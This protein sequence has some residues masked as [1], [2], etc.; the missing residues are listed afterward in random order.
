MNQ[1]K[2]RNI[3]LFHEIRHT[4]RAWGELLTVHEW[5]NGGDV[6]FQ[7]GVWRVPPTR[8]SLEWVSVWNDGWMSSTLTDAARDHVIDRSHALETENYSRLCVR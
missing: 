6:K 8:A 5:S 4:R 7:S 3:S 1:S 2:H